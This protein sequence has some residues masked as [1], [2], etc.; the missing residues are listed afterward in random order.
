MTERTVTHA[1]FTIERTYPGVTPQRVFDAWAS[2]QAK[3]RWFGG[4]EAWTQGRYELD[5]RV[6]GREQASGG[7]PGGV[8]H[9]YR[10][11]YWDIVPGERIV[12][13][14]EMLMDETRTSVSVATVEFKADGAGTKLVMTEQGAYLDGYD[15]PGQREAGTRDLLDGLARALEAETAV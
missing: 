4:P 14:Y 12:S 11:L 2:P 10:A 1:I 15:N 5:F 13:T 3:S 7:P 6:G 8:V 9:N